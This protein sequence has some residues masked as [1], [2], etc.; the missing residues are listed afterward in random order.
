MNP[1]RDTPLVRG[2]FRVV[3]GG[4]VLLGPVLLL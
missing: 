1:H 2:L 3:V 4:A